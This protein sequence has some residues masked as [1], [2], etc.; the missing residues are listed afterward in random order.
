MLCPFADFCYA[1]FGRNH[2]MEGRKGVSIGK[3][4]E[5]CDLDSGTGV[6]LDTYPSDEFVQFSKILHYFEWS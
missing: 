3:G 1:M 5:L 2:N 6:G 4:R